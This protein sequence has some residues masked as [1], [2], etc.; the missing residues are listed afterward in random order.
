M[1][2]EAMSFVE[3]RGVRIPLDPEIITPKIARKLHKEFY[4]TP[5]VTGLP[6]FLTSGDRV[7]ELGS[8]IGFISTFMVKSIGV[9]AVTCVEANPKLCKFIS[10]VHRAN[11]VGNAEIFNGVALPDGDPCLAKEHVPFYVSD[12]FWSSSL[13]APSDGSGVSVNVPTISLS[14]LVADVKPTAIICDIEGGEMD[15]FETVDLTGVRYVFMEL[16]TRR[17]GG[18]GIIKVFEKMH[19]H[20]FYYR[21]KVSVADTVLFRSLS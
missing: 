4:E 1:D 12:P 8:G 9:D 7:L 19:R 6:K 15:L 3:C 14:K 20:G 5:E 13:S 10:E 17:I 2:I 21:Q 11:D 16:H 18:K